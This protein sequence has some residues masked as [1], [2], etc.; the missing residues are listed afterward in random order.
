MMMMM[1]MM[2]K[3]LLLSLLLLLKPLQLRFLV[4]LTV[5]TWS[6]VSTNAEEF[7]AGRD[8]D[9]EQYN[10]D[11]GE[12]DEDQDQEEDYDD[13]DDECRDELDAETCRALAAS[14]M[15]DIDDDDSLGTDRAG[16]IS[17]FERMRDDCARTCF[18]CDNVY[19]VTSAGFYVRNMYSKVP[20]RILFFSK[21]RTTAATT[22]TTK[23][24]EQDEEDDELEPEDSRARLIRV[25]KY[26]FHTVYHDEN[27]T[28]SES[29]YK[30][31][32]L[33]C[34]NEVPDCILQA[35]NGACDAQGDTRRQYMLQHCRPAC[36]ACQKD[37]DDEVVPD[38]GYYSVDGMSSR[39]DFGI[40]NSRG[41]GN[42]RDTGQANKFHHQHQ[43]RQQPCSLPKDPQEGNVWQPGTAHHMF[44]QIV[45]NSSSGSSS[46]AG[47]AT[48]KFTIHLQPR[49]SFNPL[50]P[51]ATA[52]EPW[53]VALD[54]FLT[55]AQ[56]DALIELGEQEQAPFTSSS[57]S[58]SSSLSSLRD[59][60]H[61]P[62]SDDDDDDDDDDDSDRHINDDDDA[63]E[64]AV[65]LSGHCREHFVMV[66]VLEK[67]RQVTGIPME[68]YEHLQWQ[69]YK[70]RNTTTTATTADP[71][72]ELQHDYVPY[73]LTRFQGPRILTVFLYL[74]DVLSNNHND[75]EVGTLKF[76][77][78]DVVS[79][80][81]AKRLSLKWNQPTPQPHPVFHF[82]PLLL[83]FSCCVFAGQTVA[84]KRG[85][86]V[87]WPNVYDAHPLARDLRTEY[88]LIP[89]FEEQGGGIQYGA[90]MFLYSTFAK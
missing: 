12:Q 4:V 38:D 90:Y 35:A 69:K 34:R 14:D 47:S 73:H 13:Y 58:A 36:L 22:A 11:G 51:I 31:H 55:L 8:D 46:A 6:G 15:D 82:L 26:M 21:T 43:Q 60:K 41:R 66:Q 86:A 30:R 77:N 80:P 72:V 28:S 70:G 24:N 18:L 76:P 75:K 37:D 42:G 54:D 25:D 49:R 20:Q 45:K 29:S 89:P 52:N 2:K 9:V 81:I 19:N 64:T 53:I 5:G 67:I 48:T 62:H 65:C 10:G 50:Q 56:C 87:I 27:E 88:H 1:M 74:N 68:N 57:A 61:T 17:N 83:I 16:C 39:R 7:H 23:R 40:S 44:R 3:S 78:L 33:S 63:F 71:E 79:E 85:S 84:P 32:R 59:V